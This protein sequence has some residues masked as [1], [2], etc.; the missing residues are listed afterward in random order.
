[1]I[2]SR[3]GFIRGLAASAA[4][5]VTA[6][7]STGDAGGFSPD[8][9]AAGANPWTAPPKA[10]G[11]PLRFAVIGDNT[12]IARPGVFDR[13]MQQISWLQPDFILS[14]GDLIE[15]YTDDK[16]E[17]ARQWDAV[18]RS[19]AKAG[20]PFIYTPGNHDVDNE[21]THAAWRDRRGP[22]YYAFTYKGALF[23]VLNTEDPPTAM[24]KKMADQFYSMVTLM[25]KDPDKADKTI[26]DYIANSTHANVRNG[27]YSEADAVNISDKQ[28]AFVRDALAR[29]ANVGWTF[30]ILHKPAWKMASPAFAKIQ[31]MLGQ[32][33]YSVFAGHTHYFTHDTLDGRDYINMATTGGIRQQIGPGTMDHTMLVTLGPTGPAYANTRLSGL[34]DVAGESGQTRAY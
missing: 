34:M 19:V 16:A 27:E 29:H 25:G 17:I 12:G 18:E 21:E 8:A 13:A 9:A 10:G 20:L 4:L 24:T 22:G 28:L 32:R 33:P 6:L 11:G 30:V 15:G 7:A 3:A 31:L 5:P 23:L 2:I 1:M 14:V 26:M